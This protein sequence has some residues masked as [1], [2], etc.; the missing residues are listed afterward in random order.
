MNLSYR[1]FNP[2]GFVVSYFRSLSDSEPIEID[3][4][5]FLK[6]IQRGQFEEYLTRIRQTENKTERTKLKQKLPCIT[7]AGIFEKSHKLTD[8]K[9]LS[10]LIS[11]D[12]DNLHNPRLVQELLN[13]DK[14][15]FASFLSPSGT[16]IKLIL[17]VTCTPENFLNSFLSIEEYFKINYKIEIDKSCK[18]I[19]RLMFISSDTNLFFN[20][21]SEWYLDQLH[22]D[23]KK[24]E[25]PAYF[26]FENNNSIVNAL[27]LK[28][29]SNRIDITAT[30]SDWIKIAFSLVAEFGING[31]Q[32]FH[33][34]SQ[35]F[36]SY[37]P[38]ECERV[39]NKCYRSGSKSITI[40]SL[41]DLT[42]Q[43]GITFKN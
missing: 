24:A 6:A 25:F 41:Y 1:V 9:T 2:S 18:D 43:F 12:I 34:I 35:F 14:Y 19:S 10:G 39:Y 40:K 33:R 21:H 28:I 5:R 3:I 26:N 4:M 15:T 11:I 22:T 29:E 42:K 27:V 32:Y 20:L 8:L 36:P 16:G 23:K 7:T 38:E 13:K 30:Y 31:L 37:S 17:K